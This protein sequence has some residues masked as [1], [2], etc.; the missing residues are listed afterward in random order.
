MEACQGVGSQTVIATL[1]LVDSREEH[2]ALEATLEK[3]KPAKPEGSEPVSFLLP[4]R[5]TSPQPSGFRRPVEVE[6]W[7]GADCVHASYAEIAR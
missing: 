5:Y 1:R 2:E 7:Y 4:F 6:T 3:S